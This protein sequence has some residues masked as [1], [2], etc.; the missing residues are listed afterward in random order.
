MVLALGACVRWSPRPV[1]VERAFATNDARDVAVRLQDDST[2]WWRVRQAHL[3]G[4]SIVG[5]SKVAGHLRRVAVPRD[6]V[7]EL[8]VR[9]PDRVANSALIQIGE[10]ACVVG[11]FGFITHAFPLF[12][13]KIF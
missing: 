10:L 13:P 4:D 6:R 9:E 11:V 7:V 3:V 1:P 5:E 8:V 2:H 12:G